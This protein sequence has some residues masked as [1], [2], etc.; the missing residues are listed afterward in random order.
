M[1]GTSGQYGAATGRKKMPLKKGKSRATVSSNIR[2]M[3]ASGY[4]QK[5]AV[6][7]A[8]STARK[9]KKSGRKR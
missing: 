3:K 6:A 5:Q 9:S 2:E 7:A 4:P 1:I 8:L